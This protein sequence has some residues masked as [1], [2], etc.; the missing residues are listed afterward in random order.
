MDKQTDGQMDMI[1]RCLRQNFQARDIKATHDK[2]FINTEVIIRLQGGKKC[3][4]YTTT[5]AVMV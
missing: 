1:T 5:F 3:K 2:S 4:V